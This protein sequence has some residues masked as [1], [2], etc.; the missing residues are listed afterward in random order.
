MVEAAGA[1]AAPEATNVGTPPSDPADGAPGQF[2]IELSAASI[3]VSPRAHEHPMPDSF[4]D[5][6]ARDFD[7]V[8]SGL[9]GCDPSSDPASGSSPSDA[10]TLSLAT[11]AA[12]DYDFRRVLFSFS[13][14]WLSTFI[15]QVL[16]T[17]L[18]STKVSLQR[19]MNLTT[20]DLTH[21]DTSFAVFHALGQISS[22]ALSSKTNSVVLVAIYQFVMGL[23]MTV[24]FAPTQFWWFI[25]VYGVAGFV[26]GPAWAVLFSHLSE[27]LPKEHSFQLITVW[28]TGSDLGAIIG[29]LVCIHAQEI[30]GW[31]SSYVVSGVLNML[32]AVLLF[33]LY[34]NSKEPHADGS[35]VDPREIVHSNMRQLSHFARYMRSG[36]RAA[37]TFV[38]GAEQPDEPGPVRDP[39][40][41][42]IVSG[43][44]N[45]QLDTSDAGPAPSAAESSLC[46]LSRNARAVWQ[47]ACRVT[48]DYVAVLGRVSYLGRIIV[49]CFI[50]K[51]VKNCFGSWVN[52]YVST[53]YGFTVAQGNYVSLTLSVGNCVGNILVAAI[54]RV[55]WRDRPLTAC[56]C[57]FGTSAAA[58]LAFSLMDFSWIFLS[59]ACCCLCGI[60]TT[61]AEAILMA[62]GI[63]SLCDRS[64]LSQRE[65]LI[66]Y[67]FLLAAST[68]GSVCQGFLVAFVVDG[69][70]WGML[71][72]IFV[73]ALMGA[74]WLLY[75]LAETEK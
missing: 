19:V 44:N 26:S 65:S 67:G 52:F 37:D 69:L 28:F 64:K 68:V 7:D 40:H 35:L 49:A 16:R 30:W 14:C 31:R 18:S 43:L 61:A 3:A 57:F 39:R 72:G 60:V 74:S 10:A 73:V 22:P 23:T 6:S 54:C 2:S 75:K 29:T 58:V 17:P 8:E 4:V 5:A 50:L 45:I 55:F 36:G 59:Y 24:L 41:E 21:L 53:K 20:L 25:V 56:V 33:C 63:K 66:V 70:G 34:D 1:A 32:A 38:K 48:C 15:G 71:F 42:F 47:R 12:K 13:L 51:L 27:W 62:R 46:R 9:Q 11:K